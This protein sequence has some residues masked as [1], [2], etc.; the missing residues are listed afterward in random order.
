MDVA[1]EVERARDAFDRQAWSDAYRAL[2]DADRAEPLGPDDLVRLATAAYLVGRDAECGV[3]TER[4]HH[5]YLALGDTP[6]AVRCAFW[7]AVPLLLRGET[8][9]GGG[10]L[11]RAAR[12]L[13]DG[14]LDCVERGYLLFPQG[15]RLVHKDPRAAYGLFGE[16]AAIGER[17]GD[18]DL[19]TLARHGQGRALVYAGEIAAG[20]ALLDEAMVAVSSGRLSPLVT[21]LVY[22]SVIEACEELFDLRRAQ[23]WT[24]ALSHWCSAQ[25]DLVPYRGQCLVH[26]SHVLQTHGAWPDALDEARR[27]RER[28]AGMP[29][30]AV[31]GMALYQEAELY[32]VRGAFARSE[33]AYRQAGECGH[34][35]QPGLALMWLAQGRVDAAAAAIRGALAETPDRLRRARLLAPYAEIML[36]AGDVPAAREA[37]DELTRIAGELDAP[38]LAAVAAHARGAVLLAEGAPAEALDALLEAGGIWEEIDAPYERA[39]TRVLLGLARRRLGDAGTARLE[40]DAAR[41]AFRELGAAPDLA[42]LD[43]P[44]RREQDTAAG[45]SPREV[46]VLRLVATGRTNHAIAADL[47]LSEKTVARHLSNIFG[48]L[49]LSSRAAATAYAYEHDLVDRGWA[50]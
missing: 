8:A 22:C 29:G 48:K 17:F 5:A 1:V 16:A 28:L 42:R 24:E 6:R 2:A 43:V 4:A 23:E 3:A 26:R 18:Q 41:Q 14:G 31:L 44:A 38:L 13:E 36:A 35:A 7:A 46:E 9:R 15:M 25:P 50:E 45:L 37:V 21:G 12:L 11:A 10:W 30:R 33:E 20:T 34:R 19:V 39:R 32:R 27:A 47:V 49:G 40:R